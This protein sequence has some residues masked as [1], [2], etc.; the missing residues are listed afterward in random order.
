MV[1]TVVGGRTAGGCEQKK[2]GQ[3][4]ATTIWKVWKKRKNLE[5]GLVRQK[6]QTPISVLL[7][8][9]VMIAGLGE[10]GA[11]HRAGGVTQPGLRQCAACATRLVGLKSRQEKLKV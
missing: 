7:L 9:T 11:K 2:G 5:W 6:S 10:S 3:R 1:V 4:E 8:P